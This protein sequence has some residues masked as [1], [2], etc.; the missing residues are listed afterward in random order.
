L[1]EL[2]QQHQSMVHLAQARVEAQ[3]LIQLT[4]LQAALPTNKL[5]GFCVTIRGMFRALSIFKINSAHSLWLNPL[6]KGNNT[7]KVLMVKW[8]Y[9]G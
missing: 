5:V 1:L 6:G 8:G 4:Y 7:Y 9:S 3:P 2:E